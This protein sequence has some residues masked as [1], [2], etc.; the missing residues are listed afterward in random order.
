MMLLNDLTSK[1]IKDSKEKKRMEMNKLSKFAES[2]SWSYFNDNK[3]VRNKN[4]AKDS[5]DSSCKANNNK[6]ENCK[7]DKNIILLIDDHIYVREAVSNIIKNIL[8]KNHLL[9]KFLIK[10][11][12]DGSDIIKNVIQD[13]FENNRISCIITDENMEFM[14]GSEA[15]K[16]IRNLEKNKKI[17][18]ITVASC[19]AY[20]DE[21][22][23]DLIKKSGVDYIISKPCSERAM[24]NFFQEFRI[25]DQ[26]S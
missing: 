26:K 5:R 14:N 17:K 1:V 7:Q 19:T 9:D 11:E 20:E 15:I 25:L 16:I 6:E 2:R 3:P 23:R 12:K 22:T 4:K 13:Q 8:R 21:G 24:L 18:P 10:E